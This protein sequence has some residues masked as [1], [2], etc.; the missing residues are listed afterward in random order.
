MV[1]R[2]GIRRYA[3]WSDR[4]IRQIAADNDIPLERR[5]RWTPRLKVPFIGELEVAEERRT[6]YRN[7][8]ARRVEEAIG[9]LAV[10]DFVTPPSVRFAKGTGRIVF[11]QFVGV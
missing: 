4:R 1:P 6:L 2:D 10:G 5:F 7:E 3:Y 9:E 11:S 8:M